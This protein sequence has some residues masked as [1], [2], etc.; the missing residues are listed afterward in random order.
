M[1]YQTGSATGPHDMLSAIRTF[2]LNDAWTINR[3]DTTNAGRNELCISK[4]S[5]YFNLA[6]YENENP[7]THAVSWSGYYGIMINGS[8]GYGAGNSWNGH[9]GNSIRSCMI[10][11]EGSY[12][13]Y[14]IFSPNLNCIYVEIETE[15][16]TYQRLGMGS[17]DTFGSPSGDGRFFF[18]TTGITYDFTSNVQFFQNGVNSTIYSHEFIPFR[19]GTY[20]SS[21]ANSSFS[22][23]N[24]SYLRCAFEGFDGWAQTSGRS[25]SSQT[26]GSVIGCDHYALIRNLSPNPLNGQAILSPII[27]GFIASDQFILPVGVV[28]GIRHLKM[29]LH[30][31]AEEFTFGTETWK[32]FP[33]YQKGGNSGQLALAYLRVD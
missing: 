19:A 3:Y 26:G 23:V 33:W 11:G 24:G 17:L 16:A 5:A 27:P 18:A 2:A 31:P 10:W 13:S 4:G 30:Q 1:S 12:P 21:N 8:D 32:V 6:S 7:S 25:A 29:D 15:P 20:I 9:A 14:H 22:N 28:P